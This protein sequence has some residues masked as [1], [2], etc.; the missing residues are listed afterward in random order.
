MR[1]WDVPPV[2]GVPV[3]GANAGSIES[4]CSDVS[5]FCNERCIDETTKTRTSI[6]R[7]TGR[8]PTV[9]RIFLI[10]PSVPI[11]ENKNGNGV[12]TRPET[13]RSYRSRAP[14]SFG[15]QRRRRLHSP[16]DPTR[17]FESHRAKIN[18]YTRIKTFDGTREK[19][20]KGETNE[21]GNEILAMELPFLMR[22]S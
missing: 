11:D 10:M 15:I 21:N 12:R 14:L 1:S 7:Y 9:S 3:A 17:S 19:K 18:G 8:S 4:I 20:K 2:S 22:P 16:P 13:Y 5:R 6:E